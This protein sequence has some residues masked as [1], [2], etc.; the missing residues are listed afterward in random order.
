M[1]RWV[2]ITLALVAVF[3]LLQLIPVK[4]NYP[5]EMPEEDFLSYANAIRDFEDKI[6]ISC[7]PCH[8]YNTTDPGFVNKLFPFNWFHQQKLEK[9][10]AALNFAEWMNYRSGTQFHKMEAIVNVLNAGHE[11][12]NTYARK[13]PEAAW[14]EKE[15]E[16]LEQYFRTW[17]DALR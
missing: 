8:S 7:Y 15:Y 4:P 14:N 16:M 9:A 5:D 3:L 6:K 13:H 11:P 1:S 12:F 2:K 17:R 10:R